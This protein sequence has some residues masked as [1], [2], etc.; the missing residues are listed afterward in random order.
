MCALEQSGLETN[1]I[2]RIIEF[3]E[4]EDKSEWFGVQWFFRTF[5]TVSSKTAGLLPS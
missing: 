5:D 1:F 4:K 3:F 2:G